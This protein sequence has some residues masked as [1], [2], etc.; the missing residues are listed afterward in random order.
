D[1]DVPNHQSG[2]GLRSLLADFLWGERS[3]A[4]VAIA[5]NLTIAGVMVSL[6]ILLNWPW[7]T[8]YYNGEHL[9]PGIATVWLTFGIILIC[10][11]IAQ[12]LLLLQTPKRALWAM[13]I[14][15]AVVILPPI[16]FSLLSMDPATIPEPWVLTAF[17]WVAFENLA[18][19]TVA[20]GALGQVITMGWVTMTIHRQLRQAGAS[21]TKALM[22]AA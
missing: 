12:R 7:W 10:A 13:G 20:L 19:V 8:N 22:S 21:T 2:S 15:G 14:V 5:V 17:P 3:P 9:I 11:A 16:V 6:W 1:C 4:L 18:L